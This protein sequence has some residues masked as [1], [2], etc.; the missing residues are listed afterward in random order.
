M[1]AKKRRDIYLRITLKKVSV[2]P[3]ALAP[4]LILYFGAFSTKLDM[5]VK[6]SMGFS[7]AKKAA[8]FAV[9]EDTMI[10]I[11]NHHTLAAILVEVPL[12]TGNQSPSSTLLFFIATYIGA[13]SEPCCMRPPIEN[14][15][16][17]S[18]LH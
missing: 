17:L 9:Y 18:K 14:Q 12:K 1:E 2:A 16:E 15:K 7:V 10:R 5:S 8:K 13:I 4:Y 11:K 3:P 6:S